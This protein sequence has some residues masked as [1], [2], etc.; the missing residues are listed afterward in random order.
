MG[1]A[2]MAAYS[3][4]VNLYNET[5][6]GETKIPANDFISKKIILEGCEQGDFV[7]ASYTTSL[8]DFI[9]ITAQVTNKDSITVY[10]RNLSKKEAKLPIGTLNLLVTKKQEV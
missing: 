6:F 2:Q 9:I 1:L 10:F 8:G 3:R 5:I 7:N 4:K